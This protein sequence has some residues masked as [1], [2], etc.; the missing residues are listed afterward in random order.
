MN[1]ENREALN[2]ILTE[3]RK[4]PKYSYSVYSGF[5]RRIFNLGLDHKS[6]ERALI[7]LAQI[8]RV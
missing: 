8:L 6:G 2:K 1:S 5:A 3:A 7:K 4:A